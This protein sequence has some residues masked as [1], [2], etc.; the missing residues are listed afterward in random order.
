M[1]LDGRGLWRTVTES[2]MSRV[3]WLEEVNDKRFFWK[4]FLAGAFTTIAMT[5]LDQDMMQ[6]NLSCRNLRDAQ[7]NVISYGFGFLPVNILFLSLGILLFQYAA[8]MGLCDA[9]G[10]LQGLKSDEL[11]PLLATGVNPATGVNYLPTVVGVLFVVGL[12]AAAFS[13]AGSAVTALTTSFTLDILKADRKYSDRELRRV[14][15][16]VHAVNAVVMGVLIYLFRA[17]GNHSVIDAV[18]VVAGYTYGPLLGLYFFGLYTRRRVRDRWIPAICVASPVVCYFLS[19]YSEV[20]FGGY[21]IGY[22]LLLINGGL[23]AAGLYVASLRYPQPL[24]H[25]QA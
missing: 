5:G 3:W 25:A 4:Q 12:I 24:S 8:S 17:V 13:S 1:G 22:E 19:T 18:Y 16:R 15:R 9:S 6:K 21:Q 10:A 23:T 7:K 2:P 11:F 14:R 20:L